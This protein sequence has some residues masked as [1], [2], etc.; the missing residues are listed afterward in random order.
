MNSTV[1][2]SEDRFYARGGLLRTH[3]SASEQSEQ[4]DSVKILLGQ[5]IED[6]GLRRLQQ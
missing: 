4:R 5:G 3:F 6:I 2:L 1:A